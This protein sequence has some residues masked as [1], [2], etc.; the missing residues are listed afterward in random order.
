[1]WCPKTTISLKIFTVQLI[2]KHCSWNCGYREQGWTFNVPLSPATL[3][4]W[5]NLATYNICTWYW[6]GSFIQ[7]PKRQ[8][9]ERC[10]IHKWDDT[11]KTEK[12]KN[13][14]MRC[15]SNGLKWWRSSSENGYSAQDPIIMVIQRNELKMILCFTFCCDLCLWHMTFPLV[16]LWL[17]SGFNERTSRR[18]TERFREKNIHTQV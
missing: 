17:H 6:N 14:E 4:R 7:V 15:A 8:I 5:N 9:V 18:S 3:V 12:P 13:Q 10:R 1:M 2:T 16:V 11:L